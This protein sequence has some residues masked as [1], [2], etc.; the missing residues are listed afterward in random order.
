MG[1]ETSPTPSSP[2]DEKAMYAPSNMYATLIEQ[3]CRTA[4]GDRIS[5]KPWLI[6]V[7]EDGTIV[8]F[9]FASASW[10][11]VHFAVAGKSFIRKAWA[12]GGPRILLELVPAMGQ[13][14]DLTLKLWNPVSGAALVL[15]Y[16][17]SIR[18]PSGFCVGKDAIIAA[19]IDTQETYT[20]V[21]L[22]KSGA[23]SWQVIGSLPR[24]F[25]VRMEPIVEYKGNYYALIV[26]PEHHMLE[27]RPDSTNA[28]SIC[29]TP[30]VWKPM[31]VVCQEALYMV[32]L[33]HQDDVVRIWKLHDETQNWELLCEP[34]SPVS[35]VERE[36]FAIIPVGGTLVFCLANNML[37]TFC[38]SRLE[39]SHLPVCP[40]LN[41]HALKWVPSSHD[42]Y[43]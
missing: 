35:K 10:H 39:W 13:V 14:S 16:F 1:V 7:F 21:E 9:H 4:G 17:Q 20:W 28:L 3:A 34:L 24:P 11:K 43:P 2:T 22:Y 40:E 6:Y 32:G 27:I 36:V 5:D 38:L 12:G 30:K 33:N 41:S 8:A 25:C 26:Y 18:N 19:G 31:L 23:A 15:P 29:Q 42:P 37:L